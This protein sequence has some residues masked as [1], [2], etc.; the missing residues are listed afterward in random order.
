[1]PLTKIQ[2]RQVKTQLM[3]HTNH[4]RIVKI[5]L[6]KKNKLNLIVEKDVFAPDIMSSS[7]ILARFIAK[8][9]MLFQNR[10]CLDIGCGSGILG[11]LMAKAG[12]REVDFT[13]INPK[14][15]ENTK[16][17][18][19][20]QK[21]RNCNVFKGNLF[22]ALPKKKYD[23][24][25]FNHP[26]FPEKAE[27]VKIPRSFMLKK[28]MLGGTEL[29][30]EFFNHVSKYLKNNQSIIIMPYF[31]FAGPENDPKN[32]LAKSSLKIIKELHIHSKKGTQKGKFSIYLIG[33]KSS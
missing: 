4:T 6:N 20:M 21:L 12:A 8:N 30:K 14:A 5:N 15:I 18:I 10:S 22:S 25:I 9:Q 13:D 31:Q 27:N 2:A 7:L 26:F 24:I 23:N 11:I 29:I 3:R 17:N 32:Q 33:L 16:K 28:S 1:M 19:T